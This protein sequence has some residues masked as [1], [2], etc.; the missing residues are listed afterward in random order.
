MD[1]PRIC[2]R[3]VAADGGIPANHSRCVAGCD[4]GD[5]DAYPRYADGPLRG[6]P[7]PDDVWTPE[8]LAELQRA[9]RNSERLHAADAT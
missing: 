4:Q 9:R 7:I 6:Q 3:C 5:V 8:Q 2:T 1:L